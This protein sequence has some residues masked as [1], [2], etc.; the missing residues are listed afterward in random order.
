M[1]LIDHLLWRA[2]RTIGIRAE[3]GVKDSDGN[4]RFDLSDDDVRNDWKSTVAKNRVYIGD[5]TVPYLGARS[6]FIPTE[7]VVCVTPDDFSFREFKD[8][9]LEQ[10]GLHSALPNM[11]LVQ[12]LAVSHC[13]GQKYG[14]VW[15][16][17][18][19]DLPGGKAWDPPIQDL[20]KK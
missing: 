20:Q 13:K 18:A 17:S 5:N 8:R 3:A 2:P 15:G 11:N 10:G 4:P 14:D 9:L 1:M 16:R 19:P 12:R 7:Q 6:E